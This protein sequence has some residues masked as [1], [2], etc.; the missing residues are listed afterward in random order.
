MKHIK[1]FDSINEG[2]GAD[3]YFDDLKYNYTKSLRHIILM[4]MVQ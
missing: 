2:K 1:T 3:N 4:M